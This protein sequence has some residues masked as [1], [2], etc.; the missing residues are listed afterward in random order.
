MSSGTL[1][2]LEVPPLSPVPHPS[3][4]SGTSRI[5][6]G[7]CTVAAPDTGSLARRSPSEPLA[8]HNI[9]ITTE[10]G[11]PASAMGTTPSR[12]PQPGGPD[13]RNPRGGRPALGSRPDPSPRR[14][15]GDVY[16]ARPPALLQL[17]GTQ[18]SMTFRS[19]PEPAP[20]GARVCGDKAT[21]TNRI[22]S[23]HCVSFHSII[24]HIA[25]IRLAVSST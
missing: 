24:S 7:T 2:S 1:P 22:A 16:C 18:L 13:M 23:R 12:R 20:V 3:P 15:R 21:T 19:N 5:A 10:S 11:P 6:Y 4:P 9:R 14:C 17:N 8:P 25:A